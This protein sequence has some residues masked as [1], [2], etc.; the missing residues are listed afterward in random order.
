MLRW[1]RHIKRMESDEFV[2]KVYMSECEGPKS[3]G[4]LLEDGGTVKEYMCERGASRW[5]GLDE[6]RREHLD[7]ERWR[8]FSCGHILGGCSW[9]ER[10]ISYSW[11]ERINIFY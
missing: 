7:R 4:R 6:A 3:R 2:K 10:G 11:R 5:G 1:F 9:R 8:L